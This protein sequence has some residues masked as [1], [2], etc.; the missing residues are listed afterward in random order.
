MLTKYSFLPDHEESG[1]SYYI[2]ERKHF[3]LQFKILEIYFSCTLF[4]SLGHWHLTMQRRMEKEM[5][6]CSVLFYKSNLRIVC[7]TR[8]KRGRR[9]WH[10]MV[11][12]EFWDLGDSFGH[13]LFSFIYL[14]W[15]CN[16]ENKFMSYK[17]DNHFLS[18]LKWK[19]W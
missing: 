12:C 6:I 18:L 17:K 2:D 19:S 13:L 3:T 8:Q 1:N 14:K 9:K 4:Y 7:R 11:I 16:C 15:V 5:Q 10:K